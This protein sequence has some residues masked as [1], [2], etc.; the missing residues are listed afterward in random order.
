M[1]YWLKNALKKATKWNSP[2]ML[3][4]MKFSGILPNN[5]NNN[6]KAFKT[7]QNNEDFFS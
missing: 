6:L 5:A 1:Y 3:K 4:I 7:A 2:N